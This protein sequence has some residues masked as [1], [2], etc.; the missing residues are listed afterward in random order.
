MHK[1]AAGGGEGGLAEA[2]GFDPNRVACRDYAAGDDYRQIHWAWCAHEGRGACSHIYVVERGMLQGWQIYFD[3]T[4]SFLKPNQFI[5]YTVC[6]EMAD[7]GI[8]H[9]NLGGSPENAPGL[10]YFKKRWGG[11]TWSYRGLVR[12]R[13]LGRWR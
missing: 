3:K 1:A 4:F 9:L 10:D 6:R 5:R 12:Q 7:R 13:W 8:R 11:Q 2:Y